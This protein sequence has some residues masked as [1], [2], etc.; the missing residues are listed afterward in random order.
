MNT[1]S[2]KANTFLR[3]P[4]ALTKI[5]AG[6]CTQAYALRNKSRTFAET[7]KRNKRRLWLKK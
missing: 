6:I 7:N 5:N 4:V 2:S 1:Y 3:F